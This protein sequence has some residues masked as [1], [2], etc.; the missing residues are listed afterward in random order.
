[1]PK[2]H[3]IRWAAARLREM[4]VLWKSWPTFCLVTLDMAMGKD[5]A[6]CKWSARDLL[7]AREVHDVGY[8]GCAPLSP[9]TSR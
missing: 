8:G 7:E 5:R 3:N 6:A 4:T 1:M 2:A 9:T